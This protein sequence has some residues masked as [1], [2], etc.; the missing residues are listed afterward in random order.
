[1]KFVG[2]KK[3]HRGVFLPVKSLFVIF[4]GEKQTL[5]ETKEEREKKRERGITS[6]LLIIIVWALARTN[7]TAWC[8]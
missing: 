3:I 2:E 6:L 1:M 8:P 7:T 4:C 5:N